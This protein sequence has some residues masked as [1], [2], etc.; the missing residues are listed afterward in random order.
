MS[1]KSFFKSWIKLCKKRAENCSNQFQF[2][3]ALLALKELKKCKQYTFKLIFGYRIS[4][5]IAFDRF[6]V[7]CM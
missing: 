1:I 5:C 7:V 4:S 3:E 2:L 6:I